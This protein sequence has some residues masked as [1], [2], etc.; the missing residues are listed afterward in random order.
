M[1]THANSVSLPNWIRETLAA[2][3]RACNTRVLL[4]SPSFYFRAGIT[5]GAA[6]EARAL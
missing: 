5:I 4:R 1:T 6:Q 3:A 2:S